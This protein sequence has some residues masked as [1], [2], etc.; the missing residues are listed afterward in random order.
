[1]ATDADTAPPP[2]PSSGF[3]DRHT[4]SPLARLQHVLHANPILQ[5]INISARI[6]SSRPRSCIRART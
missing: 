4:E 5:C 1:M 3:D 2:A 6:E